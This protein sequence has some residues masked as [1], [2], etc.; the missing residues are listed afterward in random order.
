MRLICFFDGTKS[1]MI[2]INCLPY[3]LIRTEV[4][5]I[6]PAYD[7]TFEKYNSKPCPAVNSPHIHGGSMKSKPN[8]L[9]HIYL[10]PDQII[11]KLSR[12]LEN[13]TKNM[14]STHR[15]TLSNS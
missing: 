5:T 15:N 8:G 11:I 2:V 4:K 3:Q 10:L 1:E 9:C 14:I 6:K 12:Y 13:S 7:M